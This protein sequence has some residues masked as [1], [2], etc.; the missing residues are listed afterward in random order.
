M[1]FGIKIIINFNLDFNSYQTGAMCRNRTSC[2]GMGLWS[3]SPKKKKLII[4]RVLYGSWF[5]IFYNSYPNLM[6]RY[7]AKK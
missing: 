7:D 2:V 1:K 5:F 6:T 3:D 4:N